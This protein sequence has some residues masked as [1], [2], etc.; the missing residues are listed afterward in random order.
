MNINTTWRSEPWFK[1]ISK[2]AVRFNT[3]SVFLNLIKRS[4]KYKFVHNNILHQEN[5]KVF[6][7]LAISN[8]TDKK[9]KEYKANFSCKTKKKNIEVIN[10]EL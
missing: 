3:A 1:R 8:K 9:G 6:D 7:S 10:K 4:V 2:V 5:T